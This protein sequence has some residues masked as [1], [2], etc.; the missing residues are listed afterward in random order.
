MPKR[1]ARGVLMAEG[2]LGGEGSL[3][4][5]S[6]RQRPAVVSE[7]TYAAGLNVPSRNPRHLASFAVGEIGHFVLKSA[8]LPRESVTLPPK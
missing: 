4:R 2:T 6:S 3:Q 7:F 1:I 5:L 8:R